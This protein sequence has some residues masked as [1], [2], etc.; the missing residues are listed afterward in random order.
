MMPV[1]ELKRLPEYACYCTQRSGYPARILAILKGDPGR[2][3]TSSEIHQIILHE[4]SPNKVSHNK[5]AE[6]LYQMQYRKLISKKGSY[7]YY[8]EG[9]ECQSPKRN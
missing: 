9:K 8:E 5:I 3:Y 1:E 7:Y 6:A 2:A 4:I